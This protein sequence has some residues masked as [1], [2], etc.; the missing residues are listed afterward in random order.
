MPEP[1]R[2]VCMQ[3]D[4]YRRSMGRGI[5]RSYT[6]AR[7]EIAR[8]DAETDNERITHLN[9]EVRF[10]N[11]TLA[12]ALYTVAFCRQ[13][14]VP[15]IAA[16]VHRGG[17][18]PII[19]TTRKRND[20]TMV[21]FGEF[22]RH[23]HSSERGRAAIARMNEIHSQFPISEDQKLYTLASLT[24]EQERI[25]RALGLEPIPAKA[26]LANYH[27]WRSVGELA[28]ITHHPPTYEAYWQ[29][30]RAYEREHWRFSSGGRAVAD[31]MIDD[32]GARLPRTTR[33]VGRELLLATFD[34]ELLDVLRLE[35]P[36]RATRRVATL[37]AATYFHSVDLLPDPPDRS[38]SD[39]FGTAYGDTPDLT[40]IGVQSTPSQTTS[41][42]PSQPQASRP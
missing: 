26:K 33:R 35:H 23:G 10:G 27:F 22:M 3:T 17:R 39:A 40:A 24:F 30:T 11:P 36:R 6:W 16:V 13:M 42:P 25:P 31:A 38:W 9:A 28:G 2:V 34:D 18:S 29:W 37:V 5:R 14:A 21:F 4:M 1:Y 15:S 20:D 32:F 19:R 8:L 41:S 7:D 12:V